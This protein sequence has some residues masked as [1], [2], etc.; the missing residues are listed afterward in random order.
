MNLPSVKAPDHPPRFSA[1]MTFHYVDVNKSE[2]LFIKKLFKNKRENDFS[3]YELMS[4]HLIIN[5]KTTPCFSLPRILN[6]R[7]S[8]RLNPM[9][10]CNQDSNMTFR[11]S[12][13]LSFFS[14]TLASLAPPI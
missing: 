5:T 3:F 2:L 12:V 8:M 7:N 6:S 13:T 11:A 14:P 9:N 1:R 10:S 4:S